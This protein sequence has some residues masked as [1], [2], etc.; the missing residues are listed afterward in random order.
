MKSC[1]RIVCS[2]RHRGMM[3]CTTSRHFGSPG[4]CSFPCDY[5][6]GYPVTDIRETIESHILCLRIE[7]TFSPP[8][9]YYIH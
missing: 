1:V 8:I 7:L 3:S 6:K 4:G 5:L 9:L 2:I